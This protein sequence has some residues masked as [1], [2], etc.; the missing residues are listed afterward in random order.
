[1]SKLKSTL[2]ATILTL[3]LTVPA[4]AEDIGGTEIPDPPPPPPPVT[5]QIGTPGCPIDI[6][7]ALLSLVI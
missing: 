6:Y 2:A 4:I 7:L 5:G 1:M 3:V